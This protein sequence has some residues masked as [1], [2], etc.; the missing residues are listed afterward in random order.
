MLP[1]A[2]F[3]LKSYTR[4]YRYFA[5]LAAVMVAMLLLYSYKPNPVMDSYAVTSVFLF[6]G[7]AWIGVSFLNHGNPRLEQLSVIH[8]GS[9]RKYAVSQILALL[10][11]VIL[12]VA[13]LILYPII[14]HMFAETV[15]LRQWMIAVAGHLTMGMLGL[16]V[17]FFFQLAFIPSSSRA[18]AILE[19][20]IIVSL[21]TE[22]ILAKLPSTFSW[23]HWIVPP[24]APMMET[25]LNSDHLSLTAVWGT[26][27]YALIYALLLTAIYLIYSA[28][29]DART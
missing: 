23:L 28:R 2:S 18:T 8:I 7:A 16:A 15:S 6:I 3:L 1:L 13:F 9:L 25:E 26:I 10:V 5:P 21:G 12:L 11:P 22:S 24:A 17:S 19:I 4:S 14:T 20:I 27:G 29:R